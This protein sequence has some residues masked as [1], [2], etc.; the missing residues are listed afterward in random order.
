M[1]GIKQCL[2]L[3][4]TRFFKKKSAG[5]GV[6]I[7]LEFNEQLTKGLHKPIIKNFKKEQF[8]RDLKTTFGE[9]I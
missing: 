4:F 2:T 1:I 3:W 5:G 9:L 6:N 7:P 8:I